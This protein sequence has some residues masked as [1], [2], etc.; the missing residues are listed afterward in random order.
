VRVRNTATGTEESAAADLVVDT[1][2]RGSRLP[3]WLQAL[4]YRPPDE[5]RVEVKIGYTAARLRT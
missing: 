3:A 2:G 4:G 5:E 1:T